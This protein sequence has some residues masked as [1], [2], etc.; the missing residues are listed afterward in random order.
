MTFKLVKQDDFA[1]VKV[2]D[3]PAQQS[4]EGNAA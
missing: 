2:P 1:D 4:Q 3:Q